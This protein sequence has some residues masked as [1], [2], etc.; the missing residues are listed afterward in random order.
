MALGFTGQLIELTLKGI[1]SAFA[2]LGSWFAGVVTGNETAK[3]DGQQRATSQVGGPVAIVAVLWG[4]GTLGLNF[5]LF[6]IA[7][8]SLTLALINILPIPA[9]DGGRLLVM[10]LARAL[11]GRPFSPEVE[12][13]IHGTGMAVLLALFVLITIVD[14]R[15]FL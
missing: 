1:G 5:V 11:K 12:D 15:R 6:I 7:I 14:V 3:N 2:G 10:Y 9:L 13:R 4:G 8:I